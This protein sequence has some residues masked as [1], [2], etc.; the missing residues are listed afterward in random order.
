MQGL[1]LDIQSKVS[2]PLGGGKALI[3]GNMGHQAPLG[4]PRFIA[5]VILRMVWAQR[6]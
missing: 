2:A 1:R 3:V 5:E 4:D 6:P